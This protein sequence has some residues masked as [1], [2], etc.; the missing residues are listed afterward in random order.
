[1]GAKM[2]IKK[3][4]PSFILL[5]ELPAASG[6]QTPSPPKHAYLLSHEAAMTLIHSSRLARLHASSCLSS[7]IR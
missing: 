2:G 1:M 7:L 4:T 6:Q 3:V 5:M